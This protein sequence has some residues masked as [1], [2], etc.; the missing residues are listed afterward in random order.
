[1]PVAISSAAHDALA[2]LY[3]Y[4]L[5]TL[6]ANLMVK[7]LKEEENQGGDISA[8][9]S[10]G[11]HVARRVI[12]SRSS[13][14]MNTFVASPVF[15]NCG[16]WDDLG[17]FYGN[18]SADPIGRYGLGTAYSHVRPWSIMNI[19]QFPILPPPHVTSPQFAE[20]YQEM[21]DYGG[22]VAAKRT[23]DQKEAALFWEDGGNSVTP[24][25]TFPR[26][27]ITWS[28]QRQW[29]SYFNARLLALIYI[30]QADSGAVVWATKYTY[31]QHRPLSAINDPSGCMHNLGF[32]TRQNWKPL[33]PTPPFPD[34]LSGHSSFGGTCVA[35][36]RNLL[37]E[38][39]INQIFPF[40]FDADGWLPG[41]LRT[42]VDLQQME[43]EDALGR[44]WGG[45]HW[46]SSCESSVQ[47]G[48]SIG[49]WVAT[50]LA[51]PV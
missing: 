43:D 27:I 37:S 15:A 13:D 9:L 50:H 51:I 35:V 42:F 23:E 14:G 18:D 17:K 31:N 48:R 39:D 12:G 28:R 21:L 22:Q 25:G 38:E 26:M 1:L 7:V 2:S 24:P 36:L 19:D 33:L 46:R 6:A 49:N 45:V 34:Y 40:T 3:P 30:A 29:T 47:V 32:E 16:D 10:L 44:I 41:K 4:P 8:S 11:H 20:E 5:H